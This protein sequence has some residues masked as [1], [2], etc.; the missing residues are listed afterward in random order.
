MDGLFDVRDKFLPLR[1]LDLGYCLS[2]TEEAYIKLYTYK[3]YSNS[4]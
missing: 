1:S 3:R 4:L 2:M